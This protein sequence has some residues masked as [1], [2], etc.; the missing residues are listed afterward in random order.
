MNL[1]DLRNV[2]QKWATCGQYSCTSSTGI[3]KYHRK[4]QKE[5]TLKNSYE[6]RIC[7]SCTKWIPKSIKCKL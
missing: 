6:I 1:D 2:Y 4:K 7:S 3:Y 5:L